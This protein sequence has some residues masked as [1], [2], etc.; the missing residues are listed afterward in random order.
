ASRDRWLSGWRFEPGDRSLVE[1]AALLVNGESISSWTPFDDRIVTV[2]G[3]ADRLPKDADLSVAIRY[4]KTS[5]PSVD[6][7]GLT[8]YFD[9][10]P[11]HELRHMRAGCGPQVFDR[12]VDLM[13]VKPTATAAGDSIEI[14]A[15][16][17]DEA[18]TPVCVVTHYRPEYA[19]TYRLRTP[20]HL[21]RG[22]RLHVRS[23][24][25][26]CSAVFD[27]VER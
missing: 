5:M 4:R 9:R 27:Y 24:S 8:L 7:S 15:Y 19:V 21:P 12:D 1:E 23:S 16:G 26:S 18:V 22:S 17:E 13:A 14:V 3:T 10:Q 11:A 2:K 25:G 20:I 6:R